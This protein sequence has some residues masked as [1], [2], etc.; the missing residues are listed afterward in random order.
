MEPPTKRQ[1]RSSPLIDGPDD[2]DDE[3]CFEPVDVSAKRDPNF[4]LSLQRAYAD[5]RFQSTMAHIFEK[6]SRNF[7]GIGDEIDMVTG[8][9]VV[10][11]GHLQNMRNEVDV[12]VPGFGDD[13]SDDD[14]G[15]L[16]GELLDDQDDSFPPHATRS[17]VAPASD[18]EEDEEDQIMNGRRVETQTQ[19]LVPVSRPQLPH[20]SFGA[21]NSFAGF[22]DGGPLDF[23]S[24]FAFGAS[25]LAF[26]ISPL[27]GHPWSLTNGFPGGPWSPPVFSSPMPRLLPSPSE[28][29]YDFP[30]QQGDSSI[31]APGYRYKE[32]EKNEPTAQLGYKPAPARP[33]TR[34]R[35]MKFICPSAAP[36]TNE[37]EVD[38]DAILMG[39]NASC[40]QEHSAMSNG[41]SYENDDLS[42]PQDTPVTGVSAKGT[43]RRARKAPLIATA[44]TDEESRPPPSSL[45]GSEEVTRRR[46][47][48]TVEIPTLDG[49]SRQEYE[50][51]EE[52][53]D[54]VPDSENEKREAAPEAHPVQEEDGGRQQETEAETAIAAIPD[55]SSMQNSESKALEPTRV[56]REREGLPTNMTSSA[57]CLSDDEMP[58]WLAQ[59]RPKRQRKQK[60]P[61]R[62]ASPA[63][64]DS[65][66]GESVGTQSSN[67]DLDPQGLPEMDGLQTVS[68]Q[69][70]EHIEPEGSHIAV[71]PPESTS[72]PIETVTPTHK[73][74]ESEARG[75]RSQRLIKELRWL[76]KLNGPDLEKSFDA[77]SPGG[78][79]SSKPRRRRRTTSRF[80][81]EADGLEVQDQPEAMGQ[82]S[83]ETVPDAPCEEPTDLEHVEESTFELEIEEPQVPS[84]PQDGGA[85]EP[86]REETLDPDPDEDVPPTADTPTAAEP[87][88][89]PPSP[90]FNQRT[91]IASPTKPPT[92]AA[93]HHSPTPTPKPQTPRHTKA[94]TRAPSSRRSILSLL[95]STSADGADDDDDEIEVDELGPQA[96]LGLASVSFLSS[97]ASRKIWKSSSR[98]TEIYHTPVKRRMTD[99]LSPS[100][101]VK[102]P[103]GTLRA[104]GLEGFR[105]GRDFCFTC[106]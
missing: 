69:Q 6:Y 70:E 35:R 71:D 102:T 105:C 38:E 5:N 72:L 10:D 21:P 37:E 89:P 62:L 91:P 32:D 59:V 39:R 57:H 80:P 22:P 86:Q 68:E 90:A 55:P 104:C 30:T 106:L 34:K 8:E 9:I 65:G 79:L 23:G 51:V 45:D 83:D 44:E 1:R 33:K 98:T 43:R 17:R 47:R 75:A 11:N 63:P 2:G 48:I 101:V 78:H 96:Q 52:I 73:D 81:P 77:S 31:W 15:L 99:V 3:L 60:R 67:E 54:E 93:A 61:R 7:E 56:R 88:F 103:G 92:A 13:E 16:L 40:S 50:E 94:P 66:I 100:S 28:N 74:T 27:A 24:P 36:N 95:S 42:I 53:P 26:G 84:Q 87:N 49:T 41:A 18:G 25:P 14:E 85:P 64:W 4:R 29:R 46:Q 97:G 19:A 12:G 82:S 58:I 76:R 20:Q